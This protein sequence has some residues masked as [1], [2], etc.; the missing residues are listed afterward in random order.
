MSKKK[1]PTNGKG[2]RNRVINKDKYDKNWER[3]FGNKK[4]R[5]K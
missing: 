3:I 4:K 1:T 5:V 2:D